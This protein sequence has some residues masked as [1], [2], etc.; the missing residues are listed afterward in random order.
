MQLRDVV[1][2][3]DAFIAE[4][5]AALAQV[6]ALTGERDALLPAGAQL[7]TRTSELERSVAMVA[8]LREELVG[9]QMDAQASEQLAQ[10]RAD[11]LVAMREP[12]R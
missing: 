2:K 1:S 10:E 9:A 8:K 11:E 4:R 5:D 7:A 6:R 3:R 12:A